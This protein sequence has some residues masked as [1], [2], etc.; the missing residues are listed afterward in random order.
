MID[1]KVKP[2]DAYR[3]FLTNHER[4]KEKLMMIAEDDDTGI[5]IY[6]TADG[7]FPQIVVI[8]DDE[9]IFEET[10]LDPDDCKETVQ[11]AYDVY[12]YDYA[13][14]SDG[15]SDDEIDDFA[16]VEPSGGSLTQDD[17]IDIREEDLTD[18]VYQM[19]DVVLEGAEDG[20]SLIDDLIDPVKDLVCEYLARKCG[21]DIWRPM[22]LEDE[23]GEEFYEEYPYGCMIFDDDPVTEYGKGA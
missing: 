15:E 19:L 4:M 5:E 23:N 22:V 7:S 13:K 21:I 3:F 8:E 17:V 18:A 10:A 6:I 1:I 20:I 2:G 11:Y 14:E 9:D 16:D 12:L